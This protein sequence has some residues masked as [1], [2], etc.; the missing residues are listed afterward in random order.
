MQKFFE[1]EE[2]GG[3]GDNLDTNWIGRLLFESNSNYILA[4]CH[5]LSFFLGPNLCTTHGVR[6]TVEARYPWS[7]HN[8][9][10][11]NNNLESATTQSKCIAF[12]YIYTNTSNH[13]VQMP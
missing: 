9:I 4:P 13:I 2:S 6:V 12:V 8:G 10:R 5:G 7:Y 1:D 3:F 11:M